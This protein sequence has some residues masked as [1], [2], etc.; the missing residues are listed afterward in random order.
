MATTHSTPA[1]STHSNSKKETGN[2]SDTGSVRSEKNPAFQRFV[3]YII[4]LPIVSKFTMFL[5]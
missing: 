4:I 1:T 5:K 3:K 2:D